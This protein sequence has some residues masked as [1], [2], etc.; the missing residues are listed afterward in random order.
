LMPA[1]ITHMYDEAAP[2]TPTTPTPANATTKQNKSNAV[3][4]VLCRTNW[5]YNRL[6]RS[7]GNTGMTNIFYID[8]E[9]VHEGDALLPADDLAILR[10]YGVFDYMRTYGG[11]PFRLDAHLKRLERSAALIGLD[12]PLPLRQ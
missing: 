1:D 4:Y 11:K 10:G 12:L 8:G 7:T 9:F 6:A 5:I 2:P 3:F